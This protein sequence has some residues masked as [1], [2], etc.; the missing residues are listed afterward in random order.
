M[1]VTL[2]LKSLS[3]WGIVDTLVEFGRTIRIT[4][5]ISVRSVDLIPLHHCGIQFQSYL[6]IKLSERTQDKIVY[7][8]CCYHPYMEFAKTY[9]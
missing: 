1:G 8:W 7:K 2:P 9:I 5:R 3:N 4:H 6:N